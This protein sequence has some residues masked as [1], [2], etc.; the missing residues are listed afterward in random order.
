MNEQMKDVVMEEPMDTGKLDAE[1]NM[2]VRG[3]LLNLVKIKLFQRS[4]NIFGL[5]IFEEGLLPTEEGVEKVLSLSTLEKPK[6]VASFIGFISILLAIHT[7]IL[8][9]PPS[10]R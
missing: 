2:L 7:D 4:I 5:R 8:Q 3:L 9:A 6:Q 10:L 1:D